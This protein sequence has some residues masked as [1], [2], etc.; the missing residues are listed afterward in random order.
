MNN[1]EEQIKLLAVFHYI[2]AGMAALFALFPIIHLIIG[3]CVVFGTRH[4]AFPGQTPPPTVLLG[5]IFVVVAL[6]LIA[7]GLTLAMFIFLA[8]RFLARRKHH[9]FCYVMAAVECVFMPFGTVLGIF[10]IIV[11]NRASVK[12]LFDA[13]PSQQQAPN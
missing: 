8:G 11:L 4:M 9:R 1:D 12:Q 13:A 5:W 2:V 3:L 7:I 6:F 10:S